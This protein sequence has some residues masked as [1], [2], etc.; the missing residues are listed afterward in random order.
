MT[1]PAFVNAMRSGVQART[2]G[3]RQGVNRTVQQQSQRSTAQSR[4]A[5]SKA[6]DSI[7][8]G[9]N[10]LDFFVIEEVSRK[11]CQND[12]QGSLSRLEYQNKLT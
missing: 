12:Q 2:N 7:T 9:K 8:N 3:A 6:T 11:C 10:Q 4:A 1:W 5:S